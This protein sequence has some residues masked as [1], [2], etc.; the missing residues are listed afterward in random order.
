MGNNPH[1]R[2]TAHSTAEVSDASGAPFPRG[3]HVERE[4]MTG[5]VRCEER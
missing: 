4:A 2:Q 3:R 1:M 5:P